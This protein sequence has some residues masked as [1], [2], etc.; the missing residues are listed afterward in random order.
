ML[1]YGAWISTVVT[2]L[3]ALAASGVDVKQLIAIS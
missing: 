3:F 1:I 2:V